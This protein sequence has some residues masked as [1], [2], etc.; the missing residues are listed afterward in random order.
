MMCN[1]MLWETGSCCPWQGRCALSYGRSWG[2]RH[3]AYTALSHVPPAPSSLPCAQTSGG[4]YAAAEAQGDLAVMAC[5]TRLGCPRRM[6][7]G[8]DSSG[9]SDS[10]DGSSSDSM[11][12]S[13]GADWLDS[14][15]SSGSSD[16]MDSSDGAESSDGTDG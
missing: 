16:S 3:I 11:D 7:R 13:D 14:S 6:Q 12:S 2:T 9:S 1:S 15:G 8:V 5:L 10:S 4:P